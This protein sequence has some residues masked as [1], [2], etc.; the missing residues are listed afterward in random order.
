METVAPL[1]T[2]L[3]ALSMAISTLIRGARERLHQEYSF[4]AGVVSIAFLCLFFLILSKEEMWRFGLLVSALLVAP[5]SLQVF[6]QVLRRYNPPFMHFVPVLYAL[7]GVQTI[8]IIISDTT[9]AYIIISNGIIVFGGLT[10]QLIWLFRLSRSLERAIDSARVNYILWTGSFAVLTMGLEISFHDWNFLQRMGGESRVNFPP[11]GSLATAGYIYFLGQ[12]ILRR[13]LLDRDEIVSRIVVFIVMVLLL[14]GVYGVL[15]RL[16]GPE[17]GASGEAVNILIASTLVLILYE[18]LKIAMEKYVQRIFARERFEYLQALNEMKRRLPTFI[19]VEALLNTLFDGIL[20][21]GRVDL[22]SLYLYD[23]SRGGYRL[24]RWEGEPEHAL[25]PMVPRH[26]V[27]DGFEDGRNWYLLPELE[28]ESGSSSEAVVAPWLD[29]VVATL[30][31]LQAELCLPLR[32]GTS[33]LGIWQLRVQPG[34]T[35]FSAAEVK[36]LVEIADLVAV[37]IDNSRAFERMKERDRLAALGQ[38]SAGLAHEIRNPLGAIKGA[39]QLLSRK[40]NDD[41]DEFRAIILEEV[42]RLDG[43][44]GQFLDYARPMNMHLDETDPSILIGGV[45]AMLEAQGIPENIQVEYLPGDHVP[46][47]PMDLEK[48]KQ[49]FINLVRNGIEAMMAE[50]GRLTIRTRLREDS[51]GEAAAIPS[52][53]RRA[54]EPRREV[55]VRRGTIAS[56]RCV[57]IILD[58][59]GCGFDRSD[60]RKL[61]I[62]FFTTKSSGTGLGLPICE[63]IMREH[64]GEMELESVL[65][66]GT[67]FTLRL[68]LDP[69]QPDTGNEDEN[70]TLSTL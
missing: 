7:A 58:D 33:V 13:R 49:V 41:D 57:E 38:M 64:E 9:S 61:F 43:V 24:R 26:P 19:Q 48:L 70:P 50:G 56:A 15:V 16:I 54:P 14:T 31:S 55:R 35:G 32:I 53:R 60:A 21:T 17:T 1:F 40:G 28:A 46:D 37:L 10:I 18:P 67:R 62:P 45:L 6:G 27:I 66:E 29:G 3:I 42:D 2:A 39:T 34:S 5:A 69:P 44:V 22:A 20:F 25:L 30:Q 52:L 12:I 36:L 65:G 4:L 47:V 23:E 51:H 8:A 59:E 63:R 11:I 68:P